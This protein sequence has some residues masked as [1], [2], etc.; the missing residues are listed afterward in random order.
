MFDPEKAAAAYLNDEVP[1]AAA[2][3]ARAQDIIA[4]AVSDD[5]ACRA[6][7][8]R[9]YRAFGRI[10]SA[11]AKDEDSV[12]AQYYDFAEPLNKIPGHRVWHWIA[13]SARA[14]EGWHSGRCRPCGGYRQLDVRPQKTGGKERGARGR[15]RPRR[16][17]PPHPPQPGKRTAERSCPMPP[18]RVL[19][20]SL[21]ITCASCFYSRPSAARRLWAWTPATAWAARSPSW[22]PPARC[23]TRTSSTRCLSSSAWIRRK[24]YQSDGFEERRR[25]HGHRQRHGNHETEEF[26]AQVIRELADEKNLHL[27]YMV[28]SE[29]GA[30][31]YS[32]SKLAAEEFPSMTSTCAVL[33]PLPAVCRGSAGRVGQ[34]RPQGRRRGPVPARYAPEAAERDAGRRG[35]GLREQCRRRPEH[36]LCAAAARVAGVSA[37][38][39][40]NIVAW[41][42]EG[43]RVHL[44]CA[45]EKVK[46]LGP[47]AYEQC[48]GFL[49]LPEAK[50][51]LDA[52][53]VHPESYAAAKAL[54]DACRLH[55]RRDRY[56]QAGGPARRC[57]GQ[58]AKTLCETLG[59]GEPTLNDIVAEL[60]K[61]GR[62]VRDS[63]P[64]RCC[65]VTSWGWTTS[66]PAWS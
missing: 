47:K 9:Y 53:A 22:T 33:C 19:S 37:A 61:P 4:E 34:N 15:C 51:R 66:N 62:D 65:A 57:Q 7:L 50:N 14:F 45:A 59:V 2:A 24:N 39:A 56:R 10:A 6:E 16:I 54:L 36:C 63:L 64:S 20:R 5:A 35:R 40:K 12:Y 44:P 60:C 29:A 18:P 42:E 13:A 48:A 49:R 32:A 52:T 27:Q 55:R 43:G 28:V 25:G 21:A 46:G 8:R 23:W 38:T 1:D 58:G 3:L 11:K 30:S 17:Q 31:V 26:A 41:R